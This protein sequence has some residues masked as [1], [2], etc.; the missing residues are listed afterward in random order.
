MHA[1]LLSAI[2]LHAPVGIKEAAFVCVDMLV[3]AHNCRSTAGPPSRQRTFVRH[4]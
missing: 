4:L 1:P 3:D 2:V